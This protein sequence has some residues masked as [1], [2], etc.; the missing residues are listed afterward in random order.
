MLIDDADCDTEYPEPVDDQYITPNGILRGGESTPLLPTIHVVRSFQFLTKL[1]KSSWITPETLQSTENYLATCMTLFP[2]QLLLS[3]TEPLDP[4]SIAPLVYFQ[5]ARLL[6]HRHNLSPSCPPGFR[7]HAV[8]QCAHIALD[9]ARLLSRCIAH[10][11]SSDL[12]DWRPLLAASASTLLC[13]HIWRCILFLLF[14]AEYAPASILV[15][16]ASAIG[17]S[18]LVNISCGRNISFFLRSLLERMRLGQAED[19]ETD[20]EIMVYV[21][22]DMQSS[23]DNGWVWQGSETG[24]DLS[25]LVWNRRS[26][27]AVD[28]A[29]ACDHVLGHPTYA[30]A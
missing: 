27:K 6:L 26:S 2:K 29:N 9:T 24:A 20:E 10:T 23:P 25:N 14:R 16:A 19:L 3:S 28:E 4:R 8:N 15:E 30:D 17:D 1:F 12:N 7:L 21:S 13:T 5:N 11:L 18:R 22:G